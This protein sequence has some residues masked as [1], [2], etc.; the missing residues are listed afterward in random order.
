MNIAQSVEKATLIIA[1]A[2]LPICVSAQSFQLVSREGNVSASAFASG[3]E[4]SASDSEQNP[5]PND[6]TPISIVA[7]AAAVVPDTSASAVSGLGGSFAPT[8][9]TIAGTMDA[10]SSVSNTLDQSA[11]GTAV[12]SLRTVFTVDAPTVLTLTGE[13]HV[14]WSGNATAE[15]NLVLRSATGTLTD[16]SGIDGTFEFQGLLQPGVEYT[17]TTFGIANAATANTDTFTSA[18]GSFTINLAATAVPAPSS[19]TVL[20]VPGLLGM[21]VMLRRRKSSFYSVRGT[22]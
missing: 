9:L 22:Q 13:S 12:T 14:S 1:L 7:D 21:A 17:L 18:Q 19:L 5:V 11:G 6:A 3:S 10:S 20:G 4:G 16:L 8:F 2:F 15:T